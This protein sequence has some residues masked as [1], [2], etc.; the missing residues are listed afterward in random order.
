MSRNPYTKNPDPWHP[1]YHVRAVTR[2]DVRQA[3]LTYAPVLRGGVPLAPFYD[4]Q[5][6][7][8][9]EQCRCWLTCCIEPVNMRRITELIGWTEADLAQRLENCL[10]EELPLGVQ[11]EVRVLAQSGQPARGGGGIQYRHAKLWPGHE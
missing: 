4:V 10:H 5:V 1:S 9:V 7:Q 3:A 6:E 8:N 2:D 11:L